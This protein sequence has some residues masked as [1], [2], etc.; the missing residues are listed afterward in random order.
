MIRLKRKVMIG[1]LSLS[2]FLIM[3]TAY[4]YSDASVPLQSWYKANFQLGKNEVNSKAIRG[5]NESKIAMKASVDEVLSSRIDSLMQVQDVEAQHAKNRVEAINRDYVGQIESTAEELTKTVG[6][7]QFDKY[8]L[9][10]NKKFDLEVDQLA[11]EV[12]KELTL[13]PGK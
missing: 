7:T 13:S 6:P 12:L 5:L 2:T 1:S 8:V 4:A 9:A 10:T 3:G 11:V